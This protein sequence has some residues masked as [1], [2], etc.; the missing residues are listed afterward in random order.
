M[1]R[2]N[3]I[4]IKGKQYD[5][6][7]HLIGPAPFKNPSK[8]NSR[9][10][11]VAFH[12]SPHDSKSLRVVHKR[13]EPARTLMRQAVKKPASVPHKTPAHHKAQ[14]SKTFQL[15]PDPQ[16]VTRAKQ[17]DKHHAVSRFGRDTAAPAMENKPTQAIVADIPVRTEPKHPPKQEASAIRH[18]V[19]HTH[20][21]TAPQRHSFQQAID[22]ADSH[23]QPKHKRPPGH[24]R[25]AHKIGVSPAVFTLGTASL[26]AVLLVGIVAYQNVTNIGMRLASARAGVPASLPQHQ[27]AGFGLSGPIQYR[28]GQISL[29]FQS[30]SDDRRF[31][32]NQHASSWD[33][34]TLEA[35]FL[36]SGHIYTQ[37]RQN[38]GKTVYIY[39]EH[40]ATWIKDG[41]WYQIEGNSS[42]NNNQLLRLASS[43]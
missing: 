43:F 41:I 14:R 25:A 19:N 22:R 11:N 31:R 13:T 2:I 36:D 35:N 6:D 9:K 10:I 27:P 28:P 29:E 23:H 8:S 7:G 39:D 16:R 24:H 26:V 5:A 32:I 33:E 1:T 4:E 17:T 12:D 40:N 18:S 34:G 37:V 15:K 20:H 3:V 38:D 30:R 42:L 21:T